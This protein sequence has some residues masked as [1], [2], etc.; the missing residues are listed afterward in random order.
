[1]LLFL[2]GSIIS[3]F[4]CLIPGLK[5]VVT[6]RSFYYLRQRGRQPEIGKDI[7][8][9]NGPKGRFPRFVP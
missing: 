6:E 1:M 2:K 4:D 9:L 7:V 5:D 8:E 3:I